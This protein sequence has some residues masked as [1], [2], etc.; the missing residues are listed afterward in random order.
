MVWARCSLA[1]ARRARLSKRSQE[2]T[3]PFFELSPRRKELAW[4]RGPSRLSET[5]LS[6]RGAGQDCVL[7]M[8]SPLSLYVCHKFG[9][10]NMLKVWNEWCACMELVHGLNMM[11]L[12][13]FWY[14]IWMKVGYRVWH[15]IG[16]HDKY[17]LGWWN[18]ICM[19]LGRN[20][21]IVSWWCLIG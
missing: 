4:A 17:L 19:W 3:V 13:W 16:M 14:G 1:Q 10:I 6:K 15:E 18:M 12:V 2:A 11:S 8:F 5:F 9:W 7:I 21:T 20:S